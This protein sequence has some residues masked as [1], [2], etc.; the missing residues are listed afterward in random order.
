MIIIYICLVT[1]KAVRTTQLDDTDVFGGGCIFLSLSLYVCVRCILVCSLKLLKKKRVLN[2]R[3]DGSVLSKNK[4]INNRIEVHNLQF[5]WFYNQ[6]HGPFRFHHLCNFDDVRMSSFK[7]SLL[8]L[9]CKYLQKTHA[10]QIDD[11]SKANNWGII[12]SIE[13][14]VC[15]WGFWRI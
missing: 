14:C 8:Q 11:D 7:L 1:T 4:L 10:P 15:D 3:V 2:I 9:I 6:I 13:L 5:H 12:K